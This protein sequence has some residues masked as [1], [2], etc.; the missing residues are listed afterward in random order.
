[1]RCN[2]GTDQFLPSLEAEALN[3]GGE[4][5]VLTWDFAAGRPKT[6]PMVWEWHHDNS[7]R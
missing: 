1:M 3:A 7:R 2:K 6:D 4:Q 5:S